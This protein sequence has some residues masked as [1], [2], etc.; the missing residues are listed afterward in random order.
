MLGFQHGG[1]EG[2]LAELAVAK[3]ALGE[4]HAAHLAAGERLVLKPF[5]DDELGAAAADVHHQHLALDVLGMA[6]PDR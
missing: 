5:A 2:L 3:E 6:T 4:A 1:V